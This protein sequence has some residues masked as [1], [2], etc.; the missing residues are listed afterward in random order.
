MAHD[1]ALFDLPDGFT[2]ADTE[3]LGRGERRQR[4]IAGRIAN[5]IHPLGRGIR[6]HADAAHGRDGD[7]LRCGTCRWRE[8]VRHHDKIYPKCYFG[9]GIRVS[10]CESSDVRVWWPACTDYTPEGDA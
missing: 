10:G 5:H 2:P 9:N 3:K 6:L 7:G 4:L 8:L 1:E